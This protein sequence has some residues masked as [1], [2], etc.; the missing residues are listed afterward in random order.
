MVLLVIMK[1]QG[2]QVQFS[3]LLAKMD[4]EVSPIAQIQEYILAHLHE[5]L[6]IEKLA[7]L[8]NMSVRHFARIFRQQSGITP[9]AF[10]LH[11]RVDQARKLLESTD[12]PL[13]T[14]SYN[15]GF[16]STRQMGNLFNQKLGL[17]PGQYRRQY[18]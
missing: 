18:R 7:G 15:C 17:S 1:R 9:M 10:V 4:K 11:G 6:S 12:L 14:V 3:P 13:K 2:G 5:P 16:S 8:A